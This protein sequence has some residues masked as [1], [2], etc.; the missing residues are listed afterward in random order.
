MQATASSS[1]AVRV[2]C[3]AHGRHNTKLDGA[4]D[5]TSNLPNVS[6]LSLKWLVG[7]LVRYVLDR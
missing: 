7:T 5:R 3:L 6:E 1:V 4:R 2:E